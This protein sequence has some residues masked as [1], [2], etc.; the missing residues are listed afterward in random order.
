MDLLPSAVQA[1]LPLIKNILFAIVLFIGGWVVSKWVHRLALRALSVRHLDQ[2]LARFVA[3]ILRY[4]VLTMAILAAMD[5]VGVHTTSIVAILASA[6]LAVGLALQGSLG[7]FASGVMLLFFR[8][9]QIGDKVSIGDHSGV[10]DEIGV[11]NTVLISSDNEKMIIPNITV[12]SGTII[13]ASV[14]GML[15]GTLSV[16]VRGGA[17]DVDRV[18]ALLLAAAARAEGVSQTPGPEVLLVDMED[19][20]LEFGLGIW[21]RAVDEEQVMHCLRRAV[22]EELAAGNM[23]L[24]ERPKLIQSNTKRS[25]KQEET[26]H[27]SK[28]EA[29]G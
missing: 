1:Q 22:L 25:T 27:A 10:V 3:A 26:A 21:Y 24:G 23:R 13:N 18:I 4:V 17:G 15:R 2:A 6:G 16:L 5:T 7:N 8:P 14:R 12:T 29:E 11:F 20:A 28:T 19:N 9:F